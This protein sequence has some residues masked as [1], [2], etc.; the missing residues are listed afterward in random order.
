MHSVKKILS[1][2]PKLK[3]LVKKIKL[4]S[5]YN[6]VSQRVTTFIR[7]RPSISFAIAL[8]ILLLLII[9]SNFIRMPAKE[10]A[11]KSQ[12]AKVVPIY[13][14]GKTPTVDYQAKIEKTGIIEI[15]ALMGGVVQ[16]INVSEGQ[17]VARG[18]NLVSL[19]SNY[20]GGNAA[21]IQRQLA[22]T[23]YNNVVS[24]MPQQKDL[25]S[26]QREIADQTSEN[27]EQL[28]KISESVIGGIESSVN[29]NN[30]MIQ[31]LNATLN[32]LQQTNVGGANNAQI[33][34]T[35]QA[36][37][38][39][40]SANV[41]LQTQL[42]QTR[43]QTN[44]ENPP[45]ELARLQKDITLKQLDIQDKALNLSL[46]TSRLQLQLAQIAEA[47]MYPSAPFDGVVERVNVIPGQTVNP[48]ETLVIL[49]GNQTQKAVVT[50]PTEVAQSVSRV[51]PST[52]IMNGK[53]VKLIPS[54]ISSE[55]TYGQLYSIMY[56]IPQEYQDNV[57]NNGFITAK[58]PVGANSTNGI[59]PFVPLDAVYQTQNSAY[60]FVNDNGKA[61][62]RTV[63]L[64]EVQGEYVKVESGIHTGDEIIVSRNVINGDKVKE[65]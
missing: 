7:K 4:K 62:S 12:E 45:T 47:T 46:E 57:T 37:S 64:G 34:Q 15:K 50:V 10:T 9:A 65:K 54:Y 1:I 6:K 21:S 13:S 28:R 51:E 53:S 32:Q 52:L 58:I 41:Q 11:Q 40:N 22:A 35:Q 26:K 16:S 36:L 29:L 27:T 14:I 33:A 18:T 59:I 61:K 55:A 25:I 19:S 24:T 17:V 63:K 56:E 48:G 39:L 49:H 44:T 38:Q 60:V 2:Q 42:R 5:Q 20:S 30:S 43:Y 8:I 3:R 31:N 23:Q